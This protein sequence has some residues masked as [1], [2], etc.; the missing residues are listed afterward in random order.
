M[1]S[2]QLAFVPC[3]VQCVVPWRPVRDGITPFRRAACDLRH[4]PVM[5]QGVFESERQVSSTDPASDAFTFDQQA[6]KQWVEENGGDL[7]NVELHEFELAATSNKSSLPPMRLR[8][9][10]TVR[11]VKKGAVLMSIPRSL[12]LDASRFVSASPVAALWGAEIIPP[13]SQEAVLPAHFRLAL[14]LMHETL[15]RPTSKFG[16]Y[17]DH[18]PTLQQIGSL[19]AWS[20]A[21]RAMLESELLEELFQ[22]RRARLEWVF[23]TF[24]RGKWVGNQQAELDGHVMLEL[25]AACLAQ[26]T[27]RA[28]AGREADGSITSMLVPF[29]DMANHPLPHELNTVKGLDETGENFVVLARQ[30]IGAQ[31]QVYLSYGDVPNMILLQQFGFVLDGNPYSE[32]LI[33]CQLVLGRGESDEPSAEGSAREIA[34]LVTSGRL[35]PCPGSVADPRASRPAAPRASRFQPWARRLFEA[36]YVLCQSEGLEASLYAKLNRLKSVDERADA[37]ALAL[38]DA[39]LDAFSSTLEQDVAELAG[40]ELLCSSTLDDRRRVLAL[41]FRI[42]QKKLLLEAQR[43]LK[44]RRAPYILALLTDRPSKAATKAKG[45]KQ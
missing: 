34:A 11:A 33:D 7:S 41:K 14:A 24:V 28:Y 16:I 27:S 44:S 19:D 5:C 1:I 42:E 12:I 20:D 35:L 17:L 26:V 21:Q 36:I 15:S 4:A 40:P 23:N 32:A 30:N 2:V 18:L 10:R 9:V 8:G 22:S 39:T 29:V 43:N 25:F 37:L 31:Q 13:E 3:P 6:L 45:F 38:V